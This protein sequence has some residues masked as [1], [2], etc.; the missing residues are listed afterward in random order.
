[1]QAALKAADVKVQSGA[2]ASHLVLSP[3]L[4]AGMLL[5]TVSPGSSQGANCGNLFFEQRRLFKA[6]QLQW[7]VLGDLI[8]VLIRCK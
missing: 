4:C 5:V 2:Q 1:M 6:K 8:E 3:M 7:E